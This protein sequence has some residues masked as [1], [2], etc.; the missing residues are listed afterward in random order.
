[1]GIDDVLEAK[2]ASSLRRFLDLAQDLCLTRE[3]LEHRLD[4][5]IGASKPE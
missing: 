1:M 5:E 4:H 2:I 3:V